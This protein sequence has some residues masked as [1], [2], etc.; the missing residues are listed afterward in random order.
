[1]FSWTSSL[2]F[3]TFFRVFWSI[4]KNTGFFIVDTLSIV[5]C[6]WTLAPTSDR[7]NQSCGWDVGVV[8]VLDCFSANRLAWSHDLTPIMVTCGQGERREIMVADDCGG[9]RGK[10]GDLEIMHCQWASHWIKE[11]LRY[12]CK[13]HIEAFTWGN[14]RSQ[15]GLS[16][17]SNKL[18]DAITKQRLD[19][20]IG[21][22]EITN[23]K[24]RKRVIG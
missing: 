6:S 16:G 10:M 8:T 5:V 9:S 4:T 19:Q 15:R 3:W 14:G 18:R 12:R 11:V 21:R 20:L 17:V 7:V 13:I 1:M 23:V 24:L 22:K 2:F